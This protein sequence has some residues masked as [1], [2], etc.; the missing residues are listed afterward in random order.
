MHQF[1]KQANRKGNT[2]HLPQPWPSE[3]HRSQ[4]TRSTSPDSSPVSGQIYLLHVPVHPTPTKKLPS[5]YKDKANMLDS[6]TWLTHGP[7]HCPLMALLLVFPA[8]S[9]PL[10]LSHCTNPLFTPCHQRSGS[11]ARSQE[12]GPWGITRSSLD[13]GCSLIGHETS[14]TALCYKWG[15]NLNVFMKYQD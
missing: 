1:T 12:N 13:D 14:L 7:P 6:P 2:L 11:G 4:H 10:L 3:Q 5:L 9:L 15:N 8:P